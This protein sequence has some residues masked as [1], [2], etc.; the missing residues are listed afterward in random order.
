MYCLSLAQAGGWSASVL[1]FIKPWH[2]Y[3]KQGQSGLPRMPVASWRCVPEV[4]AQSWMRGSMKPMSTVVIADFE[5]A[6]WSSYCFGNVDIMLQAS[7]VFPRYKTSPWHNGYI[8]TGA[9]N[10]IWVHRYHESK[11]NY[12]RGNS[13][14]GLKNYCV[15]G[16]S[17]DHSGAGLVIESVPCGGLME[18][19][20]SVTEMGIQ[21]LSPLLMSSYSCSRCPRGLTGIHT[22][23]MLCVC[24]CGYRK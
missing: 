17:I 15:C 9:R 8:C 21:S 6:I 19:V 2:G 10:H 12:N 5:P 14:P 16:V 22:R 1:S 11:S 23:V 7:D 13:D 20:H 4:S 3:R 18:C 24:V